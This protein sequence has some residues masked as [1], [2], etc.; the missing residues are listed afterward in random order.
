[1]DSKPAEVPEMA[2]RDERDVQPKGFIRTP[3]LEEYL[4]FPEDFP[5]PAYFEA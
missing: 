5:S 2:Q 4:C 3:D 1:M